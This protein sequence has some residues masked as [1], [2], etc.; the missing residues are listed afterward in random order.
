MSFWG[1]HDPSRCHERLWHRLLGAVSLPGLVVRGAEQ[2][3]HG[4]SC[5]GRVI[6]LKRVKAKSE[7]HFLLADA[8]ILILQSNPMFNHPIVPMLQ[9]SP[10]LII[11][12]HSPEYASHSASPN[13]CNNH[14]IPLASE[15]SSNPI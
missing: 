2:D 11:P 12:H 14:L 15:Q 9:M 6:S 13:S 3:V 10:I 5:V 7:S 1:R 8:Q 4:E